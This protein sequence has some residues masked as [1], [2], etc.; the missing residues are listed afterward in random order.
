MTLNRQQQAEKGKSAP[1]VSTHLRNSVQLFEIRTI[2]PI[3]DEDDKLA[4]SVVVLELNF[5]SVR[6][7][8]RPLRCM[9]GHCS[10]PSESC[11]IFS[12]YCAP[13]YLDM[14]SE[15]PTAHTW[16]PASRGRPHSRRKLP[17][18]ACLTQETQTNMRTLQATFQT[19]TNQ[20]QGNKAVGH[21]IFVT[22]NRCSRSNNFGLLATC[23]LITYDTFHYNT[24]HEHIQLW[25]LG[26]NSQSKRRCL[27]TYL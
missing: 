23:V 11:T 2:C 7:T 27:F 5:W 24:S 18:V 10:E 12:H 15:F 6:I 16:T 21:W 8:T 3:R 25:W 20:K 22:F 4:R 13:Y 1:R 14:Y 17:T 19:S 26:H 9:P